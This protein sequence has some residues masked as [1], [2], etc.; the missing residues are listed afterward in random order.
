MNAKMISGIL[1]LTGALVF[2]P[3]AQAA[4]A[5]AAEALAKKEGCLKCHAVDKKKEA[6]SLKSI[7]K[8]Y[9]GKA[10]RVLVDAPCS[11]LGVLRHKIDLRWRKNPSDLRTLP[12]LQRRILDSA[13]QC[14]RPGGI[15]VYST[16][17]MNDD[18]N[19]RIVAAFLKNHPEFHVEN[20]TQWLPVPGH[21]GPFIQLLPQRDGLDG[22]F[23]AR[24]KKEG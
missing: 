5:A 19:S 9:A 22:F 11:G 23:I 6:A 2:A 15:L 8:K 4:D 21:E 12:A 7:A 1:S 3:V 16:C 24:M 13:S 20:A 17:T 18:E 10:D 14:V